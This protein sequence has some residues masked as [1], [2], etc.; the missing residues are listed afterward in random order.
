MQ[1][2]K[3]KVKWTEEGEKNSKFFLS[4]EKRN[5]TN[6][7]IKAL[8]VNGTIEKEPDKIS[9]EQLNNHKAFS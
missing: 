2:F 6:K 8:D 9:K 1:I 3:S 7:L 5:F 4:L